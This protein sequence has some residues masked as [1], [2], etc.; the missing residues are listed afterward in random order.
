[1]IDSKDYFVD[2]NCYFLPRVLAVQIS[3]VMFRRFRVPGQMEIDRAMCLVLRQIAP[4]Y[5]CTYK[6]TTN[7]T[8]ASNNQLSVKPEFF[9]RGNSIMLQKYN[10]ELPWKK[11]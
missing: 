4:N 9:I 5:D 2:V 11:L 3:P 1:V 7:Y 10:G 8:V 6:Y